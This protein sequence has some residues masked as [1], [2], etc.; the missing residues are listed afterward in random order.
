MA[1][2]EEQCPQNDQSSPHKQSK[3]TILAHQIMQGIVFEE[4][5]EVWAMDGE[6]RASSRRIIDVRM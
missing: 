5:W 3:S 4:W 6:W 2:Q 1:M